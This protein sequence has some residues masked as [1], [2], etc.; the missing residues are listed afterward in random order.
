M[1]SE[2]F[3]FPTT[4]EMKTNNL[5]YRENKGQNIGSKN[6]AVL[7]D[8]LYLPKQVNKADI[9]RMHTNR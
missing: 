8:V 9:L 3:S 6:V 7:Y 5:E 2:M 1:D 4:L